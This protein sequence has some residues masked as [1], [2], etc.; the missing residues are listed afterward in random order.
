MS[1]RQLFAIAAAT[2]ALAVPA[3]SMASAP[4]HF[5]GG[6]LGYV[7]HLNL[8]KST[9]SR[10]QVNAEVQAAMQDGSLQALQLSRQFSLPEPVSAA[11][12]GPAKTRA[13]VRAD[14]LSETP[15]QRR[16]RQEW[17]SNGG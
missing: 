9:K 15:A 2:I 10:S 11:R 16:E 14:L 12:L 8:V 1:T 7:E 6:E 4:V 3:V 5:V 17:Y 13:E